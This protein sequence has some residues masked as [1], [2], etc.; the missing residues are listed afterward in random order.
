MFPWH[1]ISLTRYDLWMLPCMTGLKSTLRKSLIFPT[2][3]SFPRR[4]QY[5]VSTF[6]E[7]PYLKSMLTNNIVYRFIRSQLCH[8]NKYAFM[9]KNLSQLHFYGIDLLEFITQTSSSR[10]LSEKKQYFQNFVQESTSLTFDT[11]ASPEDIIS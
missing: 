2:T 8:M 3:K 10:R 11:I 9:M 6:L 7:P 5:D 1:H 4:N